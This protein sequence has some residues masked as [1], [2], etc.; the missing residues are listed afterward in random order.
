MPALAHEAQAVNA[1]KRYQRFTV[2]IGNPP[3]AGYS[4]NKGEWIERLMGHYKTTVRGEERQIQR[5]SNDYVKFL[6]FGE[7]ILAEAGAGCLGFITDR[8]Y[9]D[10]ILFRDMRAALQRGFQ[11]A[12][13]YDLHGV[14]M[15]RR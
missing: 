6:R 2:V 4:A 8:G 1:V 14:G 3:Y 15:R 7:W 13:I 9:L 11:S 5:L 10:G 12:W